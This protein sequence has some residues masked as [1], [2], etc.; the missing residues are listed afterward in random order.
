LIKEIP[1]IAILGAGGMGKTGLAR[2]VLHCPETTGKYEDNRYFVACDPA[3]TAVQLA[4]LIASHVGLK[5]GKNP[6]QTV[7]QHFTSSPPSLLILDN[8]ETSWEP[9]ESRDAVEKFLSSLTDI[10]HLAL[11]VSTEQLILIGDY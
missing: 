9:T 5:P 10:E 2:A 4:A 11:I 6:I 1:R 7:I 8:L 3:S